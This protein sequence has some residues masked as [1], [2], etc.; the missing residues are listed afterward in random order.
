MAEFLLHLNANTMR[1]AVGIPLLCL[2]LNLHAAGKGLPGRAGAGDE[3]GR[4]LHMLKDSRKS[5][6]R[7]ESLGKAK[8]DSTDRE[9]VRESCTCWKA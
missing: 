7:K 6:A 4:K 2:L 8:Q 9:G 3:M 5:L 1:R